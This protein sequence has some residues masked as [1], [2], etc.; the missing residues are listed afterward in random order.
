ME[1]S[2]ISLITILIGNVEISFASFNI[3]SPTIG[4]TIP[5]TT[6]ARDGTKSNNSEPAAINEAPL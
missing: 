2:E 4:I 3:Y 5:P 1:K 6:P